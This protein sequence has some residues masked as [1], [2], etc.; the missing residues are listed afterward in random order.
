[1]ADLTVGITADDLTGAADTAAALARP[2]SPAAV[3]LDAAPRT[4]PGRRAFAVTTNSR[5]CPP[6]QVYQL[7]HTSIGALAGAG[8][9]LIYNKVDSNL[10]GNVGAELAALADAVGRPVLFAPAFPARERTIVG[11][12]CLVCETPVAETEMGRDPEAPVTE[13]DVMAL[14]RRQR[15]DL[16][17]FL[18]PLSVVRAGRLAIHAS[19]P[20][21]GVLVMDTETDADLDLIAEVALSLDPLPALA[22]SAGLAAALGRRLFGLPASRRLPGERAAPVLAVLASSSEVLPFQIGAAAR[23]GS[24]T[25]PFRSQNLTRED[26]PVPELRRAIEAAANELAAGRNVIVYASGPLPEVE[27][28]VEL[29]VEHLAHLAFVVIREAGARGLLVGGGSTAQA[30]LEALG[31]EAVEIEDEPLPGMAAGLAV[32]GDL[33]GRP[34]ALKPGAAGDEQAVVQLLDYL[35]RRASAEGAA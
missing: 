8:A 19:L 16:E 34:V 17:T 27:R 26:Q 20:S 6:D 24:T 3:S 35:G 30:V 9:D 21:R 7:V 28:P 2:G 29:V 13:S 5:A 18:C 32:N 14:L 25:I 33:A 11:G 4:P 12:I 10:R 1:M 23:A 22:G 15:E 31:T